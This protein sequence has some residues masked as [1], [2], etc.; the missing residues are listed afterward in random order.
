[1]KKDL[2]SSIFWLLFG[3]YFTI[4][5]YRTDLGGWGRPGPGYFPFG[6]GLLFGIVSLWVL[7]STLRKKTNEMPGG[8][9]AKFQWHN[10]VLILVGMLAYIL[11]FRKVGFLLCTFLL[12]VLFI[13]LVSHRTWFNSIVVALSITVAFYLFFDILLNAQLPMGPFEFLRGQAWML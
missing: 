10:I 3:I 5:S 7:L 8:S 6:A 4:E 9:P 2:L 11:L 13:R 1:M 12:V